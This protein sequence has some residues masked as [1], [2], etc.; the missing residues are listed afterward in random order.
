[1]ST[2]FTISVFSESHDAP[3]NVTFSIQTFFTLQN[4]VPVRSG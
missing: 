4:C 1:M 2:D 3:K